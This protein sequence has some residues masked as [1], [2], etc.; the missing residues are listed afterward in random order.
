M[1]YDRVGPIS[2]GRGLRQ[3]DPLSPYLFI[4]VTE[5]LTALIHQSVGRGDIHGVRICRGAPEVSHL[6]FAD[7]CFLFCRANVV[8]VNE[9]MRILHTYEQAS[10]Q[11][12]NLVKSEVFISRNMSHVAK[13]DLSRILGV[14]LVLGT[15]IYLGL[16][17]MVGRSGGLGV[18]K[19]S[20]LCMTLGCVG[21]LINGCHRLNLQEYIRDVAERILE[22]PL[23]NSIREDKVVWE[24]ERN[25]CYS[26]KSGYKL[27]MRY[28][29][30]SDKYH[31]AG[32]WNGIW[33]AQAPHKAR[34]L[35]WRLCRG[36]LPTRYRLLERR[37][38]CNLNCPVCDEEIEDEIHIFF[39]C[40]VAR[41]SWCAA[42]MR[43]VIYI[44]GRVTMLLWC[45]WQNRNDKLW[46]DNVQ[47]PRQIGRYV[48]DA[49]NDWYSVHK[50]QSNSESRTTEA[51]LV[52]WKKPA[53]GWVKC[54]VDVAFV[55]DSGRTSV[56][57]C[58]RNN[59]GQ[60][61]AGMTQ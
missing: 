51:D 24:E 18:G 21:R 3:G 35:L 16:P 58:F 38:E 5:C 53:L 11:E 44:V 14:R 61:M 36:C 7:D 15:G 30:G 32:N 8:E 25:G 52:R 33:K 4:L 17:S 43:V 1:N 45:I 48:F 29:I 10:G 20:V 57:L 26:V 49:W 27:V 28:I 59:R 23:V 42:A 6:L 54:N 2:P 13:E 12:I 46:N 34:H 39:R 50:L 19:I 41:D 40:A 60:V 37:V 56:G 55:P 9:L 47:T 22:T 31:V